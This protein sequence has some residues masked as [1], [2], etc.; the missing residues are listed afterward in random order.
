MALQVLVQLRR[1]GVILQAA[2]AFHEA[3]GQLLVKAI[4]GKPPGVQL[5]CLPIIVLKHGAFRRSG[6]LLQILRPQAIG[7][8]A[9]PFL[10]GKRT[11]YTEALQKAAAIGRQVVIPHK[12]IVITIQLPGRIDADQRFLGRDQKIAAQYFL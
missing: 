11:F 1:V 8:S 10:K 9:H 6:K 12:A 2:I 3:G 7:R 4:L 5:R